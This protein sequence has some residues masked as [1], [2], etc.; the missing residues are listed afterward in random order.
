[1]GI[2]VDLMA[3]YRDFTSLVF[4]MLSP[5]SLPSCPLFP[6]SAGQTQREVQRYLVKHDQ[7][8]VGVG[9]ARLLLLIAKTVRFRL[10]PK[11]KG[12]LSMSIKLES[13]KIKVF[14]FKSL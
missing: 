11:G 14:F 13:N 3:S 9:R 8:N 4:A 12:K 2:A 10:H 5:S 7:E 1:M 6:Q